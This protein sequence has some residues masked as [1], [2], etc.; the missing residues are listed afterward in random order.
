MADALR[1]P[2]REAQL[3]AAA[4]AQAAQA[5]AAAAA[6][7]V[8]KLA[9]AERAAEDRR[10][11]TEE[12]AAVQARVRRVL[13]LAKALWQARGPSCVCTASRCPFK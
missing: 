9:A 11:A 6:A 3:V 4:A 1:K 2:K 10:R 12:A 5:E 7:A 13:A 8:A